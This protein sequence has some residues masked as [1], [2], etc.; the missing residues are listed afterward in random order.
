M[1]K[2]VYIEL[3]ED[4]AMAKVSGRTELIRFSLSRLQQATEILFTPKNEP[5]QPKE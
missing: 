4:Y 3:I 5:E 1:T 2:E